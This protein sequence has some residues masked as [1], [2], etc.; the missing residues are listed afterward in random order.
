MCPFG[1]RLAS[2]DAT[3]PA[4]PACFSE[5]ASPDP[6]ARLHETRSRSH[7][8]TSV[9]NA[10]SDSDLD[11]GRPAWFV[12]ATCDLTKHCSRRP[13][14]KLRTAIGT[15]RLRKPNGTA[16]VILIFYFQ[17]KSELEKLQ[18]Y[19]LISRLII[20]SNRKRCRVERHK[21][22]KF[23]AVLLELESCFLSSLL[24]S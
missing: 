12:K 5:H 23:R 21:W 14:P 20:I 4:S 10:G 9:K 7:D 17:I 15:L 6:K 24:D 13:L 19:E 11:K 2:F 8:K 1:P 18:F 22:Q 16:L 3:A